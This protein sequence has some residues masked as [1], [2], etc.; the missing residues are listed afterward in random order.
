MKFFLPL[1]LAIAGC[2]PNESWADDI[3]KGPETAAPGSTFVVQLPGGVPYTVE[4][5][6]AV[7]IPLLDESG[8]RVLLIQG[9]ASPGYTFRVDHQVVHPTPEAFKSAPTDDRAKLEEWLFRNSKDEIVRDELTVKVGKQPDPD[10]DPEPGPNP[11]EPEPD[12]PAPIPEPGFRVLIKFE[13]LEKEQLP[14]EQQ[15]ILTGTDVRNFLDDNCTKAGDDSGYRIYD[16]DV[17]MEDDLEVW[18]KAMARPHKSLPWVVISNGKT[19]FEG[20]LPEGPTAFLELA[21]KYLP[22]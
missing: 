9:A 20:P 19:G 21:R 1:L 10:V 18:Q 14:I 7:M 6:P 22:K 17:P 2:L 15:L 12:T 3:I 5:R 4:P 13:A 11:P 8:N 16:D